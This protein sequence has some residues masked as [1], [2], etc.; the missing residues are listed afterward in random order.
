MN[1]DYRLDPPEPK[2]YPSCP[3]C[4]S[5]N[6]EY[7][8]KDVDNHVCGCSECIIAVDAEDYAEEMDEREL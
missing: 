3:V 4:G 8:F 6:Y 5:D 1:F 7:I 2:P